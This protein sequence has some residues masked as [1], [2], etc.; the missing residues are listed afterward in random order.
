MVV[1]VDGFVEK[2]NAVHV[3]FEIHQLVEVISL[4]G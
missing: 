1:F 2:K 4:F 3:H